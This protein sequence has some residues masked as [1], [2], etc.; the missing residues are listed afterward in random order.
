MVG[1]VVALSC[2]WGPSAAAA[3]GWSIQPTPNAP[4]ATSSSL[5]GVSC[6]NRGVCTAV[7]FAATG[8]SSR[9]LAE[10]WDGGVWAIQPTPAIP[11]PGG[12][13]AVSCPHA[14]VCM[15]VGDLQAADFNSVTLAERWDGSRWTI[16]PS[17]T[18]GPPSPGAT[19]A[20]VSCPTRESCVAVG[21]GGS[22]VELTLAL[23]WNGA[24][25]SI[26]PTRDPPGTI[27]SAFSAVSCTAPDACT[28]AGSVITPSGRKALVERWDGRTWEIQATPAPPGPTDWSLFGVSCTTQ[29]LCTATGATLLPNG[30]AGSPL[31]ERWEGST[32]QLQPTPK[33]PG[34]E[35]SGLGE[36]S[37]PTPRACT[38]LGGYRQSPGVY[39]SFTER[40]DGGGWSVQPIA[41][42]PP[43]LVAGLSSV[44]C[45][46]PRVCTAV[47]L[48]FTPLPDPT[49]E[50]IFSTLAERFSAGP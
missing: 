10:R 36:V 1:C 7:G 24:R 43:P 17:P 29:R 41:T 30:E 21:Y 46:G 37:C 26:V 8:G 39:P 23:H 16:V 42:L 20:S 19:V 45:P 34:G 12:L 28:A 2:A 44:S 6:P 15:A 4:G 48:S 31:A 9:P 49:Q 47:G 35:P 33:H 11:G 27:F 50:V 3:A 22:P 14:N 13:R 18:P 40:W 32:W 5:Q 25:W 38:A